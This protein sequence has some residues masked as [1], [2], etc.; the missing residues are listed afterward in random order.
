M[1]AATD[2]VSKAIAAAIKARDRLLRDDIAETPEAG[3][4]KLMNICINSTPNELL[5]IEGVI[6]IS[7]LSK[8][9]FVDLHNVEDNRILFQEIMA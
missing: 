4:G 1:T 5:F 7:A 3:R 9:R 2:E 6:L 8:M